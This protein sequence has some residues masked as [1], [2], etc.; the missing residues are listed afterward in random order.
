MKKAFLLCVL[1]ILGGAWALGEKLVHDPIVIL[2]N[3]DFTP[4]NGVVGGSGLPGDPYVIAGWKI[5]D[6]GAPFG[7]LIQGTT[8]PFVIRNVE[9]CGAKIAGIKILA[10]KNGRVED[11]LVQGSTT[12]IMVFMGENVHVASTTVRECEDGVRVLFSSGVHFTEITVADCQVGIWFTGTT[13]STLEGSRIEGCDLGTKLE[14][15]SEGNLIAGNAFLGCRIP[16]Y[17]EEGNSWDD[18]ARGNYWEGFQAPDGD[19]DGI[20]DSPYSVGLDEDRFP[21]ASPPEE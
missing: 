3:E 19:G 12:G 14:L 20:L 15:G 2:S 7:I 13:A 16:A 6:V 8:V 10:A 17:A 9:V 18:G 11:S 5:D 21:L 4:E 1:L